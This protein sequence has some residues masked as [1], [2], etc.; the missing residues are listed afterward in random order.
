MIFVLSIW[1]TQTFQ[2]AEMEREFQS[3]WW[4]HLLEA[5]WSPGRAATRP[6]A[7]ATADGLQ[8]HLP[9]RGGF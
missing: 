8:P 7:P 3:D 2:S 9:P 4:C 5:S 1:I 6:G